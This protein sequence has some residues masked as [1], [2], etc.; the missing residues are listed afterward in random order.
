MINDNGVI[1]DYIIV[2]SYDDG[3]CMYE[4]RK[5]EHDNKSYYSSSMCISGFGIITGASSAPNIKSKSSESREIEVVKKF[6][7]NN[8]IGPASKHLEKITYPDK[9]QIKYQQLSLF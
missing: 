9:I 6:F 1:T 3:K 2:Y 7:H 8:L 4:I 5:G